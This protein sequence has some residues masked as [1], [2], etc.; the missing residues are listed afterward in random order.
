MLPGSTSATNFARPASRA[1]AVKVLH[2]QRADAVPLVRVVDC[3][4]DFGDSGLDN[5][6]AAAADDQRA[7]VR[8]STATS[9]TWFTKST[10]M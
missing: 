5:D 4:R 10:F 3:E 7:P 9:A 1:I 8:F 2:Q 6:V